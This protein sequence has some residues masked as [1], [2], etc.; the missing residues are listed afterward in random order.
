M[1]I[2]SSIKSVGQKV[3]KAVYSGV[4]SAFG[5]STSSANMAGVGASTSNKSSGTSS[6]VSGSWS[7]PSTTLTKSNASALLNTPSPVFGSNA[8]G[9]VPQVYPGSTG[10][11][12]N[13]NVSVNAY[14][15]FTP[16]PS[17]PVT[18]SRGSGGTSNVS[19]VT[20]TGLIG[21]Q[22]YLSTQSVGAGS[23]FGTS[24]INSNILSGITSSPAAPSAPSYGNVSGITNAGL[25]LG[26]E[27]MVRDPNTNQYVKA[28]K[29]PEQLAADERKRTQDFMESIIPQ[30]ESVYD[31]PEYQK[32]QAEVNQRKQELANYTAQ[33]NSIVAKQNQ[34]LLTLR[35]VGAAEGVTETVYGGQAATI[36]REAAIKALPVQAQVAMAQGNLD[37][38][39]DYLGQLKTI[40]EDKANADYT[41]N[42]AKFNSIKDYLTGEQKIKL[43]NIELA[44][45]RAYDTFQKNKERL[46]DYADEARKNGATSLVGQITAINPGDPNFDTKIGRLVAQIPNLDAQKKLNE[47]KATVSTTGV[48]EDLTAYAS[49]F[50]DTGKLPSPAELKLSGLNVGQV[51]SYAKQLP[52]PSGA[53]VSTNTGVKSS[54]L[55]PTQEAGITALSE[56]VQSTLPSMQ[57]KFPK[58]YTGL[59]GGIAGKLYTTQD[60]Q[61]YNTFRQEFLSKL[62]VARSGAAVTEQEY[63][64]YSKMLPTTFN[65]SLFFGS[66]GLKKLN[67]LSTSMKSNLDSILNTQ[68]QS[69]Y[70]YSKVK[71]NG[72]ERTVGE[73]LDI[74][75]VQYRV[76]PDGTLTDII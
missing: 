70:G 38:A 43:G 58:L 60:R 36:N 49:Q 64:R 53:L 31:S 3:A 8:P 10:S 67:S 34:D 50:A 44:E 17:S 46:F 28:E 66:D 22:P 20:S 42:V 19:G 41:Y 75:G 18:I 21:T 5:K 72:E 9:I 69:I 59:V 4:N 13:Q 15:G 12:S 30:K 45:K 24:S 48:N 23:D 62:L 2:F 47:L 35:G 74:G 11:G 65:Q 27:G 71:V 25:D 61:D 54:A 76:L 32:Q 55:S 56:I 40:I 51:T 7:A 57:E 33:L 63:A 37:L 39:Q 6:G 16:T 73:V 1:S 14:G 26:M 52:K 29:T 68:Q